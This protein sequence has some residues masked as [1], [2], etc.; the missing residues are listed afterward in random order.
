[1]HRSGND[2]ARFRA[3]IVRH[4]L[5]VAALA[6]AFAVLQGCGGSAHPS[7]F[8]PTPNN[9]GPG[10]TLE[11]I[12]ITPTTALIGLAENR[13]LTALG[14]YNDGTTQDV[15]SQVTWSASSTPSTT[16][17]VSVNSSGIATGM[18]IGASVIT[19]TLGPVTGLI[20]L[21]VETN[22]FTSGT[23]AILSVPYKTTIVDAAYLPQQTMIQ[24][25][26]AVQEVNLDADQFSNVI[27]VPVALLASIPMPAGFVPNLTAASQSSFLV[28]VISYTSPNVQIIDASNLS[29]DLNNN[30]VIS[31]FTA[32]VTQKVTFNGITCM[33]CAAVVN[34]VTNQLLLST[35]QGFYT[36]DLVAGKFTPLPFTPAPVPAPIFSLNPI[37]TNPYILAPDPATGNIQILNLTTNTVTTENSGLT[38]PGAIALDLI[39]DYAAI[40]D[41]DTN[42]QSLLTLTDPQNPLFGVASGIGVCAPPAPQNMNMVAVGVSQN[43]APSAAAHTLFTSQTSGSCVGFEIWPPP[44]E[45]GQPLGQLQPS[46]VSYGYGPL[47]NTPD[48]NAFVNGSDP[49]AIAT[50]NSVVDKKNYGVLID[51]NPLADQQWIAKIN[52]GNLLSNYSSNLSSSFLPAGF[53]IPA[54][55]LCATEGN[56]CIVPLSVV[57]LPTPST[58]LTVSVSNINFGTVSVGTSSAPIPVTLSNIGALPLAPVTSLQGANA[59]DFSAASS[60]SNLLQPQSNCSIIATFTPTAKGARSALLNVG[61]SGANPQTILLSGTGQ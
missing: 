29:T 49:K 2:P 28:A 53:A 32:P 34:S 44:S 51:G 42:N 24:G 19:A 27:P 58:A 33:I 20:D 59:G 7:F 17:F 8:N 60:C 4:I 1:M 23:T 46:L 52:F 50:F 31:T 39:T 16:N 18:A 37:A 55:G 35:A 54:A 6:A 22:G 26:Y 12:Q 56:N 21:T 13:Q 40:V 5:I 45:S 9:P 10:V 15:S 3:G 36:M 30:T 61:Y 25:A 43:P 14:V 48:G 47:S 41:A 38:V 11:A 57:F